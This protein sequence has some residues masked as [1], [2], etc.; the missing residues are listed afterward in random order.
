MLDLKNKSILITG[1]TGSFGKRF[2]KEILTQY[3]NISR[4]VI[5]SR[6]EYKQHLMKQEFSPNQHSVLKYILGNIRDLDRLKQVFK[7]IDYIIHAAALKQVD[8]SEE[9]P[10]EFIKTN[11]LGT[12]NIIEA[13]QF[14]N[15]QKVI[16]LSSDK[17]V[18]PASL[19]GATKMCADKLFVAA[20]FH[21]YPSETKFSIVRYGNVIGS[22]GS[23]IPLFLK[24][25]R[26]KVLPVTDPQMTRFHVPLGTESNAILFALQHAQG[27]EI[28]V[29]KLLSFCLKDVIQVICPTCKQENIGLRIGEKKHEELISQEESL[30]TYNL[31]N[32][33]LIVPRH[34]E[35]KL[36]YYT[37][38]DSSLNKVLVNF[39][40]SSNQSQHY[41]SFS[42]LQEEISRYIA[43]IQ[44]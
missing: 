38:L 15:V 29:P 44:E 37:Q 36:D 11:I 26:E 27:G 31:K 21:P 35:F 19:Y 41:L 28:I 3:P 34:K 32:Y 24:K 23:V 39:N 25:K 33:Y 1:G 12:E 13:A 18:N 14:C 30:N 5:F 22:R 10:T 2:V 7:N 4:L 8:T 40:Y 6:D 16:A 9:N 20:N 17:A 42:E 43:S